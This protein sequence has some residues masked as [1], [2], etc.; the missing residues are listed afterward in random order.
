M[1]TNEALSWVVSAAGE[2]LT[3]AEPFLQQQI[4]PTVI[5]SAYRQALEDVIVLLRDQFSVGV[6]TSSREE[7]LKIIST[8]LGTKMLGNWYVR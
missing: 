5:I 8:C 2:M 1:F 7:M 6:D 3:A 4:H